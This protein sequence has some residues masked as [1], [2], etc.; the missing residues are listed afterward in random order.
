MHNLAAALLIY[1][2]IYIAFNRQIV[3]I[4]IFC[5]YHP[6]LSSGLHFCN[7]QVGMKIVFPS[8]NSS[9]LDYYKLLDYVVKISLSKNAKK[10]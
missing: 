9:L 2:Y 1:I 5:S 3:I 6:I 10:K 4:Q 7:N 8:L